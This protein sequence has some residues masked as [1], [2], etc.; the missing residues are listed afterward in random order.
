MERTWSRISRGGFHSTKEGF[1][2]KTIPLES[3]PRIGFHSTKEGFKVLPP[4]LPCLRV[5]RFHSTKEGFK[6]LGQAVVT[7]APKIV[8]IPPRKVSRQNQKRKYYPLNKG[9]HSTKEGFKAV[10]SDRVAEDLTEF[11]FHQGRFQ[12]F[13]PSIIW[14][15]F[16]RVSI[17]PRKVS[18]YIG[19]DELQAGYTFPFHQGRFQGQAGCPKALG[20][21]PV[22]IPPRKVSRITKHLLLALYQEFPFHQGR[23]QGIKH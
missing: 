21:G 6:A 12:G 5:R 8:S 14:T 22:S 19:G 17:P 15:I 2:V 23:F 13:H 9:F 18:R 3:I 11:P 20:C 10:R 1:K 4:L 7:I 16:S